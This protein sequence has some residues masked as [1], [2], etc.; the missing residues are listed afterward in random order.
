[1][2][3]DSIKTSDVSQN[4]KMNH[5]GRS[6]HKKAHVMGQWKQNWRLERGMSARWRGVSYGSQTHPRCISPLSLPLV[7]HGASASF[8]ALYSRE[9]MGTHVRN[10]LP[11]AI[12]SRCLR[13]G[14]RAW[15]MISLSRKSQ[16]VWGGWS[17]WSIRCRRP[18][19]GI[20]GNWCWSEE[21]SWIFEGKN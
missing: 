1:M 12:F 19:A 7:H 17:F 20:Q 8:H 16:Q 13:R 9:S 21:I 4:H 2:I 18:C 10:S 15:E 14:Q 11:H 5:Y 6:H 3:I